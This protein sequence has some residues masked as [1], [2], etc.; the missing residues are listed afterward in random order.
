MDTRIVVVAAVAE[1]NV[2]GRDGDLPWRLKS[3]LQ[4][5]KTLTEGGTVVMGRKTYESI[6]KRLGGSLPN[7]ISIVLTHN[8]NYPALSGPAL[9][10]LQMAVDWCRQRDIPN[11]FVIGGAELFR[12]AVPLADELHLTIV[13]AQPEGD[14]FLLP[15]HNLGLEQNGT[16][17][18]AADPANGDEHDFSF[19]IF[20]KKNAHQDK[21]WVNLDNAR[22]PR[23][24]A[25]MERIQLDGVCPFC[26][27]WLERYHKMPSLHE[28]NR[29]VLTEN[30]W[31]YE[32]AKPCLLVIR[33][34]HAE[35]LEDLSDTDWQELGEMA[36]W[37]EAH[38]GLRG[39]GLG[40]RFGDPQV[41]G[42][43]VRHLHVQLMSAAV[44]D[45]N[46]PAY[47]PLRLRIG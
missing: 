17:R 28:T 20:H 37:A 38:F 27:R 12:E 21:S 45:K 46:D 19:T 34:K 29:W 5:F 41:N 43:T 33:R 47:K 8:S 26:P 15:L 10:S 3:D 22:K 4:R 31:P 9:G 18:F 23:Q 42:G 44:T 11:I 1:N 6:Q 35:R 13:H 36:R 7:R 39:G 32:N 24:W 16:K 25:V 30:Q 2:I 14:A 40:F